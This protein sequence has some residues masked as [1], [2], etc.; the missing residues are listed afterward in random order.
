M[1]EINYLPERLGDIKYSCADISKAKRE[2]KFQP[3]TS[4]EEGL[5]LIYNYLNNGKNLSH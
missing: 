5:L 3:K 2:L 1:Q 4:L